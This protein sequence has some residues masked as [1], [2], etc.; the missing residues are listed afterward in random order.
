MRIGCYYDSISHVYVMFN[1]P[2]ILDLRFMIVHDIV[3]T[4]FNQTDDR[5]DCLIPMLFTRIPAVLI[6]VGE[7]ESLSGSF[8][9]MLK[10]G[11]HRGQCFYLIL[12]LQICYI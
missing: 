11:S 9:R 4:H 10:Q 2:Y 6:F 1:L 12:T 5:L 3:H 7:N 8:L